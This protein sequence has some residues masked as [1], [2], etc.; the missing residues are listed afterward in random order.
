MRNIESAIL[1]A[2]IDGKELSVYANAM[3]DNR[4]GLRDHVFVRDDNSFYALWN[5]VIAIYDPQLKR[6]ALGYTTQ[7]NTLTTKRRINIFAHHFNLP[8][9]Y[10]SH[11]EWMW[12]DE[13]PYTGVRVFNV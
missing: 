6:I 12:S 13:T 9:V 2:F 11:F 1:K 4:Y 5:T 10:Q 7:Y 3:D 8:I